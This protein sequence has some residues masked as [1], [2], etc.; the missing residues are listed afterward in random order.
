VN[1]IVAVLVAMMVDLAVVAV[2]VVAEV[3]ATVVVGVEAVDQEK[4]AMTVSVVRFLTS[5]G[6]WAKVLPLT[7]NCWD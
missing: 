6:T 3:V 1:V 4:V 7:G 2:A 5:V